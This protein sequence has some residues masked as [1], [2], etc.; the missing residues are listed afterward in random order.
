VQGDPVS[1][2]REIV[3]WGVLVHHRSEDATVP[4]VTESSSGSAL[5][6]FIHYLSSLFTKI[7]RVRSPLSAAAVCRFLLNRGCGQD[8]ESDPKSAKSLTCYVWDNLERYQLIDVLKRTLQKSHNPSDS[9]TVGDAISYE[10]TLTVLMC[11]MTNSSEWLQLPQQIVP[12]GSPMPTSTSTIKTTKT[13]L[14]SP[15]SP[16]VS[17]TS[18]ATASAPPSP[19]SPS[20][21]IPASPSPLPNE[22]SDAVADQADATEQHTADVELPASEATSPTLDSSVEVETQARGRGRGRGRGT[23]P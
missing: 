5:A 23:L 4:T 16:A 21:F 2:Q 12:S 7:H 19:Y 14:Y 1:S 13:L 6:S 15:W 20:S 18:Q 17:S 22:T 8:N 3:A 10:D 11:L 9:T